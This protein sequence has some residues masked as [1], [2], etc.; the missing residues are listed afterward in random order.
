M[1]LHRIQTEFDTLEE[2]KND[3][4]EKLATKEEQAKVAAQ[5]VLIDQIVESSEMDIPDAMVPR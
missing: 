3:I 5:N 2:Y 1:I 4:K